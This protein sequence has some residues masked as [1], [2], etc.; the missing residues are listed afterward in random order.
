MD[1]KV[2]FMFGPASK[3]GAETIPWIL[4]LKTKYPISVL[5]VTSNKE[6]LEKVNQYRNNPSV[7]VRKETLTIS[8]LYDYLYAADALV[9][10]K[11]SLPHVA[12]SSTIFQCLGSGCPIIAKDSNFAEMFDGEVMKYNNK[13]EFLHQLTDVFEGG[14]TCKKTEKTA[15]EYVK[16]NSVE[17]IANRYLKLFSEL[18][19]D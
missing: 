19:G 10:N 17:N 14:E 3:A 5:V 9:F 8:Q 16:R 13:E 6:A 11:E 7:E 18:L 15:I 4:D 12:V 1:N 2:I